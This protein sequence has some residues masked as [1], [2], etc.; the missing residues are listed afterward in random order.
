MQAYATLK[1]EIRAQLL[2]VLGQFPWI[3]QAIVFG[4]VAAAQE[5]ADS[6]IDIAVG[7][8]AALSA[9]QRVAV[10]QA[11]AERTGRPVDL[12]DLANIPEPLLGQVIQH[13]ARLLGTDAQ[14]A[15]LISRHLFEQADFVPYRNRVLAERRKAWIGR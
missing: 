3:T 14:F 13:G 2:E 4:S 11:L 6:D 12:I 1:P 7:G 10:T 5:R 15:Q 9:V 8:R